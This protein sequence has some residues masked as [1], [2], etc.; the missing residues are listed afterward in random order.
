MTAG[1]AFDRAKIGAK[2]GLYLNGEWGMLS[3][4][5]AAWSPSVPA[6]SR[7]RLCVGLCLLK[8]E[9]TAKERG[10]GGR[11]VRGGRGLVA[12]GWWFGLA[13]TAQTA[14]RLP[15]LSVGCLPACRQSRLHLDLSAHRCDPISLA[16]RRHRAR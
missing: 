11:G 12:G 8:V 7:T 16:R 2:L 13:G 5:S 10:R 6:Y 15:S 4:V 9:G 14:G 3:A 1:F